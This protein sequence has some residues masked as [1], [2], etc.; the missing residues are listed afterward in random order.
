[1]PRLYGC[2]D[3]LLLLQ[4][5]NLLRHL[6]CQQPTLPSACDSYIA[7]LSPTLQINSILDF[8]LIPFTHSSTAVTHDQSQTATRLFSSF[9]SAESFGVHADLFTTPFSSTS[10]PLEKE[11]LHRSRSHAIQNRPQRHTTPVT[12]QSLHHIAL[13]PTLHQGLFTSVTFCQ[14]VLETF[15]ISTS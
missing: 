15:Q 5:S 13:L 11:T 2:L 12:R 1:M 14:P 8:H 6:V 9:E 3:I 7:N 4:P 10:R